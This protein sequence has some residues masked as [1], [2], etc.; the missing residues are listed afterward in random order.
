M[1]FHTCISLYIVSI[2]SS[3]SHSSISFW[4]TCFLYIPSLK[5]TNS[6][7]SHALSH[8]QSHVNSDQLIQHIRIDIYHYSICCLKL[9]TLLS[10][11]H[12]HLHNSCQAI[13]LVPLARD[14]RWN[15]LIFIFFTISGTH[16]LTYTAST[17]FINANTKWLI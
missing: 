17:I 16:N 14:I 15:T 13:N 2:L 12:L 9:L 11:L 8:S 3:S 7:I 5:S 1:L 10:N 6:P 4:N